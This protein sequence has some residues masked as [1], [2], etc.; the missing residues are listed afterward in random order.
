MDVRR[1][2]ETHCLHLHEE[3]EEEYED[4]EVLEHLKT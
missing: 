4:E 1:F 2:E 3:E